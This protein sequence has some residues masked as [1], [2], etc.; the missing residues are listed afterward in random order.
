MKVQVQKELKLVKQLAL[1]YHT[2]LKKLDTYPKENLQTT[3]KK[4]IRER[5][6][7]KKGN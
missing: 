7:G 2:Q 6:F 1:D 5:I 3:L 4:T